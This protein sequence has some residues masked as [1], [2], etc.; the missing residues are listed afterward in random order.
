[1]MLKFQRYSGKLA[2]WRSG[3]AVYQSPLLVVIR[4]VV[5]VVRVPVGCIRG[6][7]LLVFIVFTAI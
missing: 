3:Y 4:V 2:F 7:I 1:M 6:R 5:V